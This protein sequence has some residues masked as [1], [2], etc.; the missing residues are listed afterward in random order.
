MGAIRATSKGG[1]VVA[2]AKATGI[3]KRRNSFHNTGACRTKTRQSTR[4]RVSPLYEVAEDVVDSVS[5][6][7]PAA[8]QDAFDTFS[9]AAVADSTLEVSSLL[10]KCLRANTK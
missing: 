1:A 8:A 2:A 10:A 9:P 5:G 4:V 6:Y 3:Q 7:M